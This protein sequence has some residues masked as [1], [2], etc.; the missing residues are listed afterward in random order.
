MEQ[1][2]KIEQVK[3]FMAYMCVTIQDLQEQPPTEIKGGKILEFKKEV[4]GGYWIIKKIDKNV[5]V[6]QNGSGISYSL[7]ECLNLNFSIHKVERE[8]GVIFEVGKTYHNVMLGNI[9]ISKF[10]ID[11][12]VIMVWMEGRSDLPACQI[13]SLQ[14]IAT[15]ILT[16]HDGVQVFEGD[17]TVF[18]VNLKYGLYGIKSSIALLPEGKYFST[19]QAA[20][21]YIAEN[22]PMF[23]LKDVENEMRGRV[24]SGTTRIILNELKALKK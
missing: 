11:A 3:T 4:N 22:K 14:P 6:S 17:K 13:S 5:Y 9:T 21:T 7:A 2:E 12:N 15:T 8:D 18:G 10:T 23:S 16:T 24:S 19:E 20:Q 1:K